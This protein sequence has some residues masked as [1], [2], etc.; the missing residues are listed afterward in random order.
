[1]VVNLAV[2]GDLTLAK[3]GI[4]G[5]LLADIQTTVHHKEVEFVAEEYLKTLSKAERAAFNLGRWFQENL[6]MA[7]YE[8]Y[9]GKPDESKRI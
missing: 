4:K 1:V 2:I 3:V 8:A 6:D 7:F 9:Q 5:L